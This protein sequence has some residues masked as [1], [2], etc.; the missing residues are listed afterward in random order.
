MD[1]FSKYATIWNDQQ[2]GFGKESYAAARAAG[3]T[4]QQIQQ[5]LVGKRVGKVA[6]QQI[7]EGI[8]SDL[9]SSFES[10]LAEQQRQIQE[11]QAAYEKRV[12]EMQQQLLQSQTRQAAAPQTPQVAT[13]GGRSMVIRAGASTRFSRPELQI[14]SMNI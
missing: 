5:G 3:L 11:Q 14:K 7:S 9:T 1:I 6:L 2:L 13:P 10:A 4:N 12:Q 8:S